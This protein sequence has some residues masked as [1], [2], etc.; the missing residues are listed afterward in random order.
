MEEKVYTIK[1]LVDLFGKL[2]NDAFI[3]ATK[4]TEPS[5]KTVEMFGNLSHKVDAIHNAIFGIEGNGGMVKVLESVDIQAKKTNGRVNNLQIWKYGLGTAWTVGVSLIVA[6]TTTFA[7][8]FVEEIKTK[9]ERID[10]TLDNHIA[11]DI[12]NN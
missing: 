1:D 8:P 6:F 11:R 12:I 5:Q 7:L 9:I 2:R 3:E 10:K 4:H